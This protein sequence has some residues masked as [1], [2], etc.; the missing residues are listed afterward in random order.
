MLDRNLFK[1]LAFAF[2]LGYITYAVLSGA[3]PRPSLNLL[4]QGTQLD[5]LLCI[6]IDGLVIL[7]LGTLADA[8]RNTHREPTLP[9][10]KREFNEF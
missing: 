8:V 5:F 1:S 7:L 9:K 4:E 6:S 10:Y 3:M 2:A